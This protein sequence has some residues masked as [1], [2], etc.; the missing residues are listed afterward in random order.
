MKKKIWLFS[1]LFVFAALLFLKPTE[2]KAAGPSRMELTT[3]GT[4]EWTSH[5]QISNFDNWRF[6]TKYW[7]F[8]VVKTYNGTT[9]TKTVSAY[10][11]THYSIQ[12]TIW[13]EGN[14]RKTDYLYSI[15]V[16]T[17][18][19]L[20]G[21]NLRQGDI[22]FYAD[23]AIGFE[24]PKKTDNGTYDTQE[25]FY[26]RC[27]HYG[28]TNPEEKY[29]GYFGKEV[30]TKGI[31]YITG[32]GDAGFSSVSGSGWYKQGAKATIT[33]VTKHGYDSNGNKTITVTK[34]ETV[35]LTST[36]W[37]H[38]VEY[39]AV[40]GSPTPD[41]FTKTYGQTAF[42]DSTPP[43]K[44]GYTFTNWKSKVT[45]ITYKPGDIYAHTQKGGTDVLVAQYV[46]NSYTFVYDPNG[47]SGSMP[48][49]TKKW[50][51]TLTLSANG[52]THAGNVSFIG[53]DTDS[54][55]VVASYK[56][57]DA[58]R[59]SDIVTAVGK[60]YEPNAHITIY[61]LW[62]ALPRITAKDRYFDLVHAQE[63]KITE[64]ELFSLASA[65]DT[66]DGTIPKGANFYIKD[67]DLAKYKNLTAESVNPSISF[68]ETYVAI[69]SAGNR[70]EKTITV[71]VV[72]TDAQPSD[73]SSAY[74]YVRFISLKYLDY[75][76]ED[77]GLMGDSFWREP[78]NYQYLKDVLSIK[79][80]NP[81][82]RTISFLGFTHEKEVPG[83]GEWN[84]PIMQEWHFS[85]DDIK[86]VKTYV[87]EH[88]IGNS[89]EPDALENFLELFK[90]CRIK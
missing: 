17:L 24:H 48:S 81:E 14:I 59:V 28:M 60:Q 66:E 21:W 87:S 7:N 25:E 73:N 62:D 42:V 61:A 20:T 83:T 11:N 37:S 23:A 46:E 36:P 76:P 33:G 10:P 34:N 27:K 51:E 75:P 49:V 84:A 8:K 79:R 22:K 54:G 65:E 80:V 4:I 12:E 29:K 72:N 74:N 63:G 88:G 67:L 35:Y 47:G 13:W 16:T 57:G 45:G 71:T 40:G 18:E 85:Q 55:K 64:E 52:F 2:I 44:P 31:F 39:D 6:Y 38:R 3:K 58:I 30:D 90:E 53:W 86:E 15:S 26:K 68:E 82:I 69:D 77:G 78:T 89:K 1:I 56:P 43:V 50:N 70:A 32:V 19:N 5:S 41:P 9:Q